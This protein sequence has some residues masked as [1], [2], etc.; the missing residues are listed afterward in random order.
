MDFPPL[1]PKKFFT[2][3][4]KCNS[5]FYTN[6]KLSIETGVVPPFW[7]IQTRPSP[8]YARTHTTLGAKENLR[9]RAVKACVRVS[10]SLL[11]GVCMAHTAS[12]VVIWVTVFS[13][14]ASVREAVSRLR[15]AQF[16][17]KTRLRGDLHCRDF[18]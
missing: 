17:S 7:L 13:F 9:V 3:A 15:R 11:W 6:K 14:E 4:K 18:R 5:R 10:P 12:L 8:G 16:E 1:A 2:L